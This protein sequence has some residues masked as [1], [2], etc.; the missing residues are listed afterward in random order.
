MK[1]KKESGCNWLFNDRKFLS[2]VLSATLLGTLVA[3][4]VQPIFVLGDSEPCP[5]GNVTTTST[6]N[7]TNTCSATTT[8]FT[9]S[10]VTTESTTFAVTTV[11]SDTAVTTIST[12]SPVTTQTTVIT[13]TATATT[14]TA[15]FAG[16]ATSATWLFAESATLASDDSCTK[17]NVDGDTLD[18]TGFGFALPASTINS[19]KVG[20]DYISNNNDLT[21]VTLTAQL[22]KASGA[23]GDTHNLVVGVKGDDC[24]SSEVITALPTDLWGTGWTS[25]DI[26]NA[27]FGVRLT[28]TGPGA[29]K[30]DSVSITINY[31]A[32]GSTT[33]VSTISTTFPVSTEYATEPVTTEYTT[34][35]VTTEYTTFPVTTTLSTTTET[36]TAPITTET[37]TESTTTTAP[38]TTETTTAPITTETTTET[39][40]ES[41]TTT[42]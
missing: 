5:T 16:T 28:S 41:T 37:T 32:L 11:S 19:I 24:K 29:Q 23:V 13:T 31:N 15:K 30:V 9:T 20:V 39:T 42:A 34:F 21:A 18:L 2:I 40:T 1:F 17:S 25:T 38:I 10:P 36:T 12:V 3:T 35:P 6:G 7:V 4:S 8:I 26:N 22:L 14:T 33:A 27:A